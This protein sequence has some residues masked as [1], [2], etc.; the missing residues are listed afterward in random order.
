[1]FS[2]FVAIPLTYKFLMSFSSSYMQP[3]ITVSNYLGF[4]AN[5][6][7]A[8]GFAFELPLVLAFLAA[9]GIATPEFL[10]QKRRHAIMLILIFSAIVTP[11]DVVSQLSLAIP[12]IFLYELGIIFVKFTFKKKS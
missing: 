1:M 9:I 10:R 7:I 8:F 5:M 6:F 2:Y 12:M 3:M 11:P 4:M